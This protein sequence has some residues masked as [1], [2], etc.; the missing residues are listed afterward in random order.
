[1]KKQELKNLLKHG[2]LL[3]GILFFT[4]SCQKD[5]NLSINDEIENTSNYRIKYLSG[6]DFNTNTKLLEKLNKV[7]KVETKYNSRDIIH[8]SEHGF[9]IDTDIAKY[10][11]TIDET[12]HSYTFIITRDTP[13]QITENLV[14]T[15]QNDGTYQTSIVSYYFPDFD[16][17]GIKN[18]PIDFDSATILNQL[19]LRD[20]IS[21][22]SCAAWGNGGDSENTTPSCTAYTYNQV[23]DQNA[24]IEDV[25]GDGGGGGGGSTNTGGTNYNDGSQWNGT[26]WTSGGGGGGTTTG[27]TSGNNTDTGTTT[28]TSP[29]VDKNEVKRRNKLNEI[30]SNPIV[31]SKIDELAPKVFS[32]LANNYKEDGARFKLIGENEYTPREPNLRTKYKTRYIPPYLDKE[33]VSVHIHQQKHNSSDTETVNTPVFSDGDIIEF[34][35]NIEYIENTDPDLTNDVT[36]ILLSEIGAFAL[37]VD[38]KHLADDAINALQDDDIYEDFIDEFERKVLKKWR[39]GNCDN[40]CMVKKITKFINTYEINGQNLG[41]HIYQAS[42]INNQIVFWNKK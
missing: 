42:I 34:L 24:S 19:Q 23:C 30:S 20:C 12:S 17:I 28:T 15:L 25:P 2:I 16:N 31:K 22:F 33:I 6:S 37:V 41:I 14:I 39:K 1:M 35:E 13:T 7:K 18:E 36:S 40:D 8:N 38:D 10:V 26:V 3:F 11:E 5:D 9:T 21:W 29:F 27:G 32:D 4:I